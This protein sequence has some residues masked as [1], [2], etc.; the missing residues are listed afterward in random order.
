MFLSTTVPSTIVAIL[1]NLAEAPLQGAT[2]GAITLRRDFDGSWSCKS[3][4]IDPKYVHS[5][6]PP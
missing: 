4:N 3:V 2:A 1:G 5:A 6:C